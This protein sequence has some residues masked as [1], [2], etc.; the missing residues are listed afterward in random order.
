M[1]LRS[2]PSRLRGSVAIPGS[3]SHTIRAVAIASL[4]EGTSQI[5]SPL[6]SLDT[7]AAVECYRAL[8]ARIRVED[9][10]TWR[11]SGTGGQPS[12][13][14]D[15]VNVGNSGTTLRIAVS[16]AALLPA[17]A[18]CTVFTGDEQIRRRPLEP[19]LAS[20]RQLGASAVSTRNNGCAPAVIGGQLRGGRTSIEAVTSQYLSSLLINCPLATEPTEI[21]VTKLNEQPYVQMTLDWLDR[22]G[23]RYKNEHFQRFAIEPG[24]RY[25]GFSY[26]IPADFSSATFF[27]CAAAITDADV[28]ILGLDFSDAQGDKAV[29]DYLRQ[30][31]AEIDVTPT[32]VRVRGGSLRGV[33]LDLNATPD[34]LP[35]MAVVGAV[36]EGTTRLTNV[37]QARVKETDRIAVM[38]GELARLGVSCKE[39]PDGLIIEHSPIRG[40][41]VHGHDD[42][43]VVMAMVVAG[44]AAKEPVIVDTAESAGVTFPQFTS[45][46]QD[47][48]ADLELIE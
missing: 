46:M 35:A 18:G 34:A 2:C 16:S 37:P 24:Q 29:V 21:V 14:S 47:L 23:I 8:G 20:L 44:L 7:R 30:M 10:G 32:C 12:P 1:K 15:V 4:A 26:R 36:A 22:Q 28:E 9:A 13:P 48:G 27:L 45:L 25:R 42:H 33:Q 11:V 5:A 38:A 41:S 43:R 6:D 31:G 40:G 3:K 19:L 39:L 17:H